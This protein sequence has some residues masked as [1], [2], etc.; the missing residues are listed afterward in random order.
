L[1]RSLVRAVL[2]QELLCRAEQIAH[3]TLF[4]FSA[5]HNIK[6]KKTIIASQNVNWSTKRAYGNCD[7]HFTA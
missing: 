6:H 1:L 4:S 5:I 2:A 3:N 7:W